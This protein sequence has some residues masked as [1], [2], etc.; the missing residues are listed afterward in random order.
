MDVHK[1]SIDLAVAEEQGEVR[2]QG[3]MGGDMS[4]VRKLESLGKE[5]VLN[6]GVRSWK[7]VR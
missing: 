4:A 3:A 7:I 6:D 2:H 5:L 1:D